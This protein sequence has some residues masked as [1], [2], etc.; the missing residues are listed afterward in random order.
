MPEQRPDLATTI[1]RAAGDAGDVRVP[2]LMDLTGRAAHRRRRRTLGAVLGVAATALVG[3]AVWQLLPGGNRSAYVPP[4]EGPVTS[5][6][7]VPTYD[8]GPRSGGMDALVGGTL[9]FT[10][11]GCTLMS[12][13]DGSDR[14]TQAVIFP[15]ATGITYDNGVRAVVD[16]NGD[17]FAVEGQ[18][19]SYGGGYVVEPD[20]E[21]GRTWL[22]QCPDATPRGG[23][24]IN[25]HPASGPLT[26]APAPPDEPGPTAPT[27][28]EELG[29]YEVPTFE[30]DPAEGG[31]A[32]EVTGTVRFTDEGCPVL[33]QETEDGTQLVGLVL[34]NAQGHDGSSG[35]APDGI[36]RVYSWLPGGAGGGVMV[37]DGEPFSSGGGYHDATH[38]TWT[39]VCRDSPVDS[40]AFV[41]DVP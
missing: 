5:T 24:V 17:V 16:G 14:V 22:A 13:G 23:A 34:P 11:D 36:R 2:P 28:D 9:W 40:V 8:W 33:E 4:A 38:P 18:E 10:E 41:Y 29:F 6:F 26:E 32:A 35:I 19:F 27:T 3:V 30:W 1:R 37:E 31:D 21:L 15:N 39:A 20:T 25:D 7:E 12:Q